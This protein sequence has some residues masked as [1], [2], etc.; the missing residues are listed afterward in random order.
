MAR[1]IL[2]TGGAGFIGSHLADQLLAEGHEVRALDALVPQVHGTRSGRPVGLDPRVD[3]R[4]GDV[5]D[6][7]TVD[8]AL[9]GVDAV[10]HLAAAVGVGQSAY[11]VAHYTSTNVVGTAVLLEALAET[12]VERL[13]VASSMSL[14]GEGRYQDPSGRPRDDARRTREQLEAGRWD[15]IGPDGEALE[16]VPTPED[17][18][19]NLTSVYAVTKH[20]QER[21][22][23]LAGEAWKRPTVALRFFNTYGPRQALGNP[24]TGVL[25][26]FATRLLNGRPPLVFED[27]LQRRDFVSVHD[28][29]R[30]CR[31]ALTAPDAAGHAFNVGTGRTHTVLE[32]AALLGDV[33]GRPLEPEI[34][35]RARVG[36]VRHCY[37]DPTRARELLGFEAGIPL[38]EGLVELADW[39]REETPVDR[40]DAMRAELDARGLTL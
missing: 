14:Y 39:L 23:L 16:P 12:S 8:E 4:V 18:K 26:I 30:A 31:L 32:V 28:V 1:T 7:A 40:V 36:D 19:P 29:A 3:L 21:L 38:S 24:Y 33:L 2:I 27:G 25:A 34:V 20:D 10:V 22:C 9:R 6:R 35:G 15:P 11:E 17:K 13:V 37:A 5:R